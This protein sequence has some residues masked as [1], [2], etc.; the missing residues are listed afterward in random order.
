MALDVLWVQNEAGHLVETLRLEAI[1][2]LI[3]QVI[4]GTR[5]LPSVLRLPQTPGG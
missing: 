1:R 2:K 4:T 5:R 3:K